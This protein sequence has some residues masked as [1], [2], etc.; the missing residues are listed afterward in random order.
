MTYG[1]ICLY[2]FLVFCCVLLYESCSG[3]TRPIIIYFHAVLPVAQQPPH[4]S[5]F[6]TELEFISLTNT[7]TDPS[8]SAAEI[9]IL[10]LSTFLILTIVN[11]YLGLSQ[12]KYW[13]SSFSLSSIPSW[14]K[15]RGKNITQ[16][17]GNNAF[18]LSPCLSA[19]SRGLQ[20]N[21]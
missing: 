3:D 8:P 20:Y 9:I 15:S 19:F 2:C 21:W 16:V 14:G 7:R 10:W 18:F 1:C 11:F 12:G 13:S 6:P 5:Y 4:R 17:N